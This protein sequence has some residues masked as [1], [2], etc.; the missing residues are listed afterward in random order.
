MDILDG[1]K[2]INQA[3]EQSIYNFIKP[4]IKA[5]IKINCVYFSVKIDKVVNLLKA[6]FFMP[7]HLM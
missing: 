7:L 3:I 1:E 6:N 2:N 4:A 5:Y